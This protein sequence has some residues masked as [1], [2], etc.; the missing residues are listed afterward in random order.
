MDFILCIWVIILFC[1][2]VTWVDFCIPLSSATKTLPHRRK[3]HLNGQTWV[4]SV[5]LD[6]KKILLWCSTLERSLKRILLRSSR[7]SQYLICVVGLI[8]RGNLN[9]LS[10]SSPEKSWCS[11]SSVSRSLRP[12]NTSYYTNMP[13]WLFKSHK[14][15]WFGYSVLPINMKSTGI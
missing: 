8:S 2:W 11:W 14:P 4:H 6:G 9:T 3:A 12:E 13:K 1:P 5:K 10:V 7:A 15:F